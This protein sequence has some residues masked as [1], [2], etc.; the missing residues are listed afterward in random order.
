MR[1]AAKV[2]KNQSL[3]VSHAKKLGAEVLH[4][5]SVGRGCPDL[6][7]SYNGFNY[8]VEVKSEKGKLNESQ[9]QFFEKWKGQVSVIYTTN[10][11]ESLLG[12]SYN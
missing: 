1:R 10:E 8:L 11:L 2:D 9:V 7:I 3:I 4:L 6:L 12:I 5:H